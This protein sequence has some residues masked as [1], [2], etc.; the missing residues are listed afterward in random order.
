MTET[1]TFPLIGDEAPS[2]TAK[3]T[4]G[5]VNFPTDYKGKMGGPLFSS[6]RLYSSMYY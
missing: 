6:C 3:T 2:F 5:E 1:H 4:H